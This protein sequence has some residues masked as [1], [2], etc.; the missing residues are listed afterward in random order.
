MSWPVPGS[1]ASRVR[2]ASLTVA[3]LVAACAPATRPAQSPQAVLPE[4]LTSAEFWALS[5]GLSEPGGYF[6]S[7]NLVSNEHT[8]QYVIPDLI[9]AAGAGGAYLGVAPDQNFTYVAALRPDIAFIL[10]VRR[11]NFLLHLIY[12]AIFELSPDRASFVSRLFSRPRPDDLGAAS[13]VSEIFD[14]VSG[15]EPSD[16]LYS[17]NLTA[18]RER[19]T[20][21]HGFPLSDADLQQIESIYFAF[22]W[23]GPSLR[24][25]MGSAGRRRGGRFPTFAELAQQTD[26]SGQQRG[27]LSSEDR[28]ATVRALQLRN[29]V[30][31]VVGN[32]AGPRALRSIGNWLREHGAVITAFY[33][34]NVEQYL[35][36]DGLFESFAGN[37]ATLPVTSRSTFIRSVSSRFGY[38][39]PY[40][41]LDGR[42]SALYPIEAFARD[43]Q[44][45]LLKSYFDL[46]ARSR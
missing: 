25:S 12:K 42:A 7:D 24:Y 15:V 5:E 38:R 29:L 11:G 8:Y 40:Q 43:V 16:T 10:D 20:G 13:G 32:F 14:A 22:Y 31:P 27:Y 21:V 9:E 4:R 37:V 3:C 28:Y 6:R 41:W 30:V 26:W 18:I 45:G 1:R 36:Q 19:L 35:F 33:V 23:E 2:A 44:K 46:N 39:G 34:S 17:E